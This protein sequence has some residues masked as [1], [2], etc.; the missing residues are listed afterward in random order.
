MHQA[1]NAAIALPHDVLAR[2]W[3]QVGKTTPS[4][5]SSMSAALFRAGEAAVSTRA[6]VIHRSATVRATAKTAA[7]NC[8]CAAKEWACA[9]LMLSRRLLLVASLTLNS[10]HTRLR[11]ICSEA[12]SRYAATTAAVSAAPSAVTSVVIGVPVAA[13][14]W[15]K[16]VTRHSNERFTSAFSG[17]TSGDPPPTPR[18][19]QARGALNRSANSNLPTEEPSPGRRGG[20]PSPTASAPSVP[21]MGDLWASSPPSQRGSASSEVGASI[22]RRLSAALGAYPKNLPGGQLV[23]EAMARF[24]A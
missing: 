6:T 10:A 11:S 18:W 7:A 17:S 8:V 5:F 22:P 19:V 2:A 4:L 3:R 15:G 24:A 9:P 1:W 20:E 16:R 13:V 21:S 12:R 23:R 14:A